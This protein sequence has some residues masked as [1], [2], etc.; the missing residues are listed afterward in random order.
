MTHQQFSILSS[1]V[2]GTIML[3]LLFVAATIASAQTETVVYSFSTSVVDASQPK[4]GLVA[5]RNSN[6]YGAAHGGQLGPGVVFQ[7]VPP[8]TS[9][10]AWTENLLYNFSGREDG[11]EPS[12]NLLINPN[13]GKIYGTATTGGANNAG[14]VYELTPGKPWTEKA[15][16][17]FSFVYGSPDSGVIAD[18]KGRLY[19]TT[20]GQST[21]GIV[22]QL[23]PPTQSGGAWKRRT[24]YSFKG[25]SDG[26][27]AWGGLVIDSSGALYGATRGG[28]LPGAGTVFK[29]TPTVG[30]GP[31]TES[32]L[33]TFQ[34]GS[35]GEGPNG[36]T[37]DSAGAL[38]G[39]T[40]FSSFST[41]GGTVFQLTP[42]ATQGG[43]WT[44]SILYT[45]T[46]NDDGGEP[47]AGIILDSSGAIYGTTMI[48]GGTFAACNA[49]LG[50][51]TV[52]K[53][54]PPSTT[55][56]AWTEQVLYSF[57]GF[58]DG[59]SPVSRLLLIGNNLYG[60]T[61]LGG[62]SHAGTVFQIVP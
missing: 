54:S 17:S 14:V 1:L 29:L 39:T 28:G 43:A 53:V 40:T 3:A 6:L 60:T 23:V 48:G 15:L 21:F 4:F 25:G 57:K 27:N 50:C 47:M 18:S 2:S 31:W 5:D 45:F 46:A 30:G 19:G 35:D 42:P 62:A 61:K 44:K 56:G 59:D 22:F 52:F 36:V 37:F 13:T 26:F 32:I 8:A 9:G 51:G 33:Y 49:G 7:L 58:P 20:S 12:G 11:G 24:L 34:N 41:V 55:G 38:Y 10:G 16:Y